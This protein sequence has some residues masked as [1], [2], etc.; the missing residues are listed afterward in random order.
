MPLKVA[1]AGVTSGLGHAIVSALLDIRDVDITLL[2]RSSSSGAT[3]LSHFTTRGA[4]LIPVDYASI[5]ELTTAISGV[6]TIICTISP[7][8]TSPLPVLNLIEASKLAGVQRF[9]P[10]EFSYSL[11]ATARLVLNDAKENVRKALKERGI[12]YTVFTNGVF[13]NYLAFGAKRKHEGPFKLFPFIVDIGSRK[14]VIPGTGDEEISLTTVEDVGK[15]VAFAV[16]KFE[17]RWPEELGME[18]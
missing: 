3:D 15:F 4:K 7:W 12:E 11:K 13:M 9:A 6:R 17:G 2:T 1:V 18:G 14:A 16:T 5:P 8:P 10:A